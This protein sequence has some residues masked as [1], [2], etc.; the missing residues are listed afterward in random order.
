MV[1]VATGSQAP[2]N[3]VAF[4]G[5]VD[6][7]VPFVGIAEA[8]ATAR[9][10]T[11][12][13]VGNDVVSSVAWIQTGAY[14][15]DRRNLGPRRASINRSPAT[16]API[17]APITVDSAMTLIFASIRVARCFLP[18]TAAVTEPVYLAVL[19][20]PFALLH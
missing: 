17:T 1:D 18:P 16:T 5:Q 8:S 6:R 20:Q 13:V 11:T 4:G 12:I 15:A 7:F 19:L 14:P 3:V 10:A 2:V 9:F